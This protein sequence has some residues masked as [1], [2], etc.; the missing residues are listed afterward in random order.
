MLL[1]FKDLFVNLSVLVALIFIFLQIR[2][3]INLEER[4]ST[5]RIF[6]EGFAGGLLGFI[7]MV[8]SIQVAPETIVD[9]RYIPVMLSV[10]YIG[11]PQAAISAA[12]IILSRFLLGFNASAFAAMV[13]MIVLISG[14][15]GIMKLCQKYSVR[16]N[17]YR[18]SLFMIIFSNIIFSIVMFLLIP[19]PL[20]LRS[21]VP[22]YWVV[23]TIGGLTAVFFVE[24]IRKTQYLLAKYEEESSTDFLTGLNNVRQFDTSWNSLLNNAKDKGEKLSLLIIDIDHFK[25]VN[26]TF[27]HSA[28]DTIL[29]ELG[30]VL[31]NATRSFDVVSRNGGEEFSIILPDCPEQRALEIAERVRREVEQHEFRI[32]TNE[33]VP[34]TVSIGVTTYPDTVSDTN[35]IVE[36]ADACLYKAK[37]T[38]RNKVCAEQ[39]A[40][41]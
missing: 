13:L 39:S 22:V 33:V 28:G 26:D 19:D 29:M 37:R 30:K 1:I 24:Y 4:S 12:L 6:I 32:D 35:Q 7:L 9:L 31:R 40:M 8:F 18:K 16:L 25:K 2:R 5:L 36:A 27:G 17:V 10:M 11:I 34:I 20:I 15:V 21:L 38:G 3:K 23:S 14:Y 41:N